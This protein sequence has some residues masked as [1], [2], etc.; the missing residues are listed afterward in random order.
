MPAC[1]TLTW[2]VFTQFRGF[3]CGAT[4]RRLPNTNERKGEGDM[5][6]QLRLSRTLVTLALGIGSLSGTALAQQALPTGAE[7]APASAAARSAAKSAATEQAQIEQTLAK[8]TRRSTEGLKVT[9]RP[10]GSRMMNL[11]GQFMSVAIATPTKDGGYEVSCD[12]GKSAV[13]LAKHAHDVAIGKAPKTLAR[14]TRQQPALEE[15]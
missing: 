8:M 13:E 12:T 5:S 15:K 7:D 3:G 14:E 10:D 6:S 1:A 9:Q 2:C 4:F 11:D